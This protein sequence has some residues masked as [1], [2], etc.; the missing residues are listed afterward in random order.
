[1]IKIM[2]ALLL[3]GMA[4]GAEVT[5]NDLL[6]RRIEI[7]KKYRDQYTE[8]AGEAEFAEKLQPLEKEI[9]QGWVDYLTYVKSL[10][11][12]KLKEQVLRLEL[13]QELSGCY[14]D[15]E[16]AEG[17]L[18]KAKLRGKIKGWEREL[19]LLDTI[20]GKDGKD[21]KKGAEAEK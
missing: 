20:A 1:M 14:Y 9:G 18:E 7:N 21:E 3:V 5:L 2:F 4:S 8:E 15:L 11:D 6:D 17:L 10:K 13:L 12:E 19:A 16:Y